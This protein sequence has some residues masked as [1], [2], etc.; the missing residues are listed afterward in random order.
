MLLQAW[1]SAGTIHENYMHKKYLFQVKISHFMKNLSHKIFYHTIVTFKEGHICSSKIY[2]VLQ[3]GGRSTKWPAL[4]TSIHFKVNGLNIQT[5][6][7][8]VS[9]LSIPPLTTSRQCSLSKPRQQAAWADLS[10]G[11]TFPTF[12]SKLVIS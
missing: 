6:V 12:C 11:H 10:V 7:R 5:S 1:L 2:S 4:L 3:S 8:V 9:S